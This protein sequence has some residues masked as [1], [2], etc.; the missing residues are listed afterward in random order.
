M[1]EEFLNPDGSVWVPQHDRQAPPFQRGN[2]MSVGNRGPLRHGAYSSRVYL[3]VAK[4]IEAEL[5]AQPDLAYLFEPEFKALTWAFCVAQARLN[6]YE[7]WA[8]ELDMSRWGSAA[9]GGVT[10]PAEE[11]LQLSARVGTLARK[12]GLVPRV[13][14]EVAAEI[15]RVRARI[16]KREQRRA[17]KK[18]QRADMLMAYRQAMY[19]GD[20]DENGELRSQKGEGK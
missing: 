8:D 3:P 6:V 19:P 10:S 1:S 9:E 4:E 13:R 15:A 5:K 14:P 18:Q 2:R 12:L 7:A 11:S 17:E 20:F 16:A